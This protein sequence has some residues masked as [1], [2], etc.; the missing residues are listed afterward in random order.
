M[1]DRK[2]DFPTRWHKNDC[3]KMKFTQDLD[4]ITWILANHT[5]RG[6]PASYGLSKD[7]KLE[8]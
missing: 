2:K 4:I 6:E 5:L 1:N 8:F 3:P 7:P